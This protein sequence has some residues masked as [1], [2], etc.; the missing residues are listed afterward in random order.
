MIN[1]IIQVDT[2]IAATMT[3][4]MLATGISMAFFLCLRS[5]TLIPIEDTHRFLSSA[6]E[7]ML[8]DG[9]KTFVA[10]HQL[11]NYNFGQFSILKFSMLHAKKHIRN[12]FGVLMWFSTTNAYGQSVTLVRLVYLCARH[13]QRLGSDPLFVILSKRTVKVLVV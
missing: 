5:R 4:V 1:H 13:S 6:V 7:F 3:Q 10:N 12:D 9:T 8:N 11:H 2:S